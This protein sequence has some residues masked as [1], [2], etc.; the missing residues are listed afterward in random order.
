MK[1][2]IPVERIERKI[3]LIRGEKVMLDRD[4]AQLYGVSTKALNQAVK[5]NKPRFPDDFLFQLTKEEKEEVVANC[6]HLSR[7]RF[8]PVLPYAFTEHGAVMAANVLN[9]S[10]AIRMSVYVVRAFIRLRQVIATHRELAQK[11]SELERRVETHDW[12]IRD[13]IS[14]IRKLMEPPPELPKDRIGFKPKP[15]VTG[16][17]PDRSRV[18]KKVR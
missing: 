16:L 9:S 10:Q 17:K 3:L 18:K 8:S 13:L 2:P 7:L 15:R 6:D 5:R 11:L 14:A 1:A 4:L 12:T